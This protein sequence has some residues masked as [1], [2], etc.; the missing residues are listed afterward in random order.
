MRTNN[1]QTYEAVYEPP[2]VECMKVTVEVGF[3][4]SVENEGYEKEDGVWDD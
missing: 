4:S 1:L 3:L 2:R